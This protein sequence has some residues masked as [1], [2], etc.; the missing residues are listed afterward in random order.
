MD[1]SPIYDKPFN[2]YQ[3][4]TINLD[5][6]E[7]TKESFSNK[8]YK[9]T[10]IN[11]FNYMNNDV[12][13]KYGNKDLTEF[14]IP[15]GSIII[16]ITIKDGKI[17]ITAPFLKTPEKKE[18]I[19]LRQIAEINFSILCLSQIELKNNELYFTYETEIE[20]TEPYKIYYVIDEICYYA[21]YYDDIFINEIG[22]ERIKNMEVTDYSE[23]DKTFLFNKFTE[24][25]DEGL[26]YIDFF[27]SNRWFSLGLDSACITLMKID[28]FMNPQGKLVT[29]IQKAIN[30]TYKKDIPLSDV[31][32]NAKKD[33]T[34]LKDYDFKKFSNN[35][36]KPFF[37]IPVKKRSTLSVIQSKVKTDYEN[38]KK[39]YDSSAYI[40]SALFSLFTI[41]NLFY[42]NTLPI[43]IE[44]FL[45]N[46]LKNVSS[47]DWKITSEKL[48][49][50]LTQLMG[51]K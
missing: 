26:Q 38:A 34:K 45:N 22:A 30:N 27:I 31:M 32:E 33:I 41:Y 25:I 13:K 14:C 20:L 3:E 4:S 48:L 2:G 43:K 29:D 11:L 35:I 5:Y 19:L 40:S 47:K 12:I 6:W 39:D 36:Y 17:S 10:I 42:N 51:M 46:G 7:K 37:L 9:D 21:D 18:N 49:N 23:K 8:K 44:D 24:Y 50:T 16:Y 15:H 28:Y 1:I